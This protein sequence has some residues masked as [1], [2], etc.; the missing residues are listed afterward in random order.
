MQDVKLITPNLIGPKRIRERGGNEF[1]SRGTRP[2]AQKFLYTCH[3]QLK[4]QPSWGME[5]WGA[6]EAVR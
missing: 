2:P 1:V 6:A 4:R 5:Y 3:C